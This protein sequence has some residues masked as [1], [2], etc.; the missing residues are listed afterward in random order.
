MCSILTGPVLLDY[1]VM[2]E[3]ELTGE[4]DGHANHSISVGQVENFDK[5]DTSEISEIF[6]SPSLNIQ[7]L[8]VCRMLNTKT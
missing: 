2:Y 3:F 6:S 5:S 7:F 1:G 8:E 4:H